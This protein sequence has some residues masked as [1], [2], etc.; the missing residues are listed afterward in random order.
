MYVISYINSEKIIADQYIGKLGD[1]I[2]IPRFLKDPS[3]LFCDILLLFSYV[4][5]GLTNLTWPLETDLS[6]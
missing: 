3:L 2:F 5:V 4:K 1:I 6:F